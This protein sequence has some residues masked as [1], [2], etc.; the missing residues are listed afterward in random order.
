MLP[1][2]P[3]YRNMKVAERPILNHVALASGYFLWLVLLAVCT[4]A[5]T[6]LAR[7]KRESALYWLGRIFPLAVAL[8]VPLLYLLLE[9]ALSATPGGR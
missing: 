8:L 6:Q 9:S 4:L 3:A 1:L 7:G 5:G 2:E